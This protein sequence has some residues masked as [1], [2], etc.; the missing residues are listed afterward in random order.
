MV[1][2][3]IIILLFLPIAMYFAALILY[4]LHVIKLNSFDFVKKIDWLLLNN[5]D[6]SK[7]KAILLA[8][9]T[10]ISIYNILYNL[11]SSKLFS[12]SSFSFTLLF[13]KIE[14]S[15]LF[16]WFSTIP[17][18]KFIEGIYRLQDGKDP[19]TGENN[20]IVRVETLYS[21]I[22]NL[23]DE[24]VKKVAKEI[25]KK[26]ANKIKDNSNQEISNYAELEKKWRETDASLALLFDNIKIT[27]EYSNEI[28]IK[29]FNPC[30]ENILKKELSREGN[31][32]FKL[33]KV[34]QFFKYY[35]IGI[36]TT[37]FKEKFN[38]KSLSYKYKCEE[39]DECLLIGKDKKEYCTLIVTT[40][41]G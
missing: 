12:T 38:G 30:W 2:S 33:P 5:K 3:I 15:I 16:A 9:L 7:R 25:G 27:D 13:G 41:N 29:F 19:N 8:I 28:K 31:N 14:L 17:L 10:L 37:I 32:E 36:L 11:I 24:D 22:K 4:H 35:S 34:C 18:E 26:F 6:S 20:V 23:K 39:E 1:I 21:L 40:N